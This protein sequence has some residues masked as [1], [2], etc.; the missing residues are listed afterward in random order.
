MNEVASASSVLRTP[1]H[2]FENLPEFSFSPHYAEIQ[3][4][5][6]HYLDEGARDSQPVLM[7]HGE[8]TWCFLYRKMISPVAAAG[9]RVLAPDLI[10]FGRS[11]KPAAI[12]THSYAFHVQAVTELLQQL[13]LKNITLVGQDWGSLIGLRVAAESP[14]RFARILIANGGL[15]NGDSP[16]S[17]G[18]QAWR[19]SVVRMQQKGD[20]D[21]GRIVGSTLGG[22]A[23][24]D[25]VKAA[26]DA[27]FPDGSYKAGPLAMPLLVPVTPED[28]AALANKAAW[29]VLRQWQKPFITAFSDG[30][31]I[32]RGGDKIFQRLI[33]GAQGQQ[34]TTI[35][36]AGHFLQEEKGAELAAVV[37]AFIRD[38]PLS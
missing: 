30:D 19:N 15:P 8:P 1:D 9:H 34:H 5:R 25:E 29:Q 14:D 4:Y 38:N 16:L 21:I 2:C 7:L 36:D 35:A 31:P 10:G 33:P 20:M 24:S 12:E 6:M 27:P 13:D 11:D 32:T 3:G 37:N 17:D 28:P 23:L 26:Y 22:K 18:F